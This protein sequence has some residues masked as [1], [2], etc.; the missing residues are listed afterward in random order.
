MIVDGKPTEPGK[1]EVIPIERFL[2]TMPIL[3]RNKVVI[4]E[5]ADRIYHESVGSILKTLEEPQSYAKFVLTSS[6]IGSVRPTIISRCISI[7]CSLPDGLE[8][9]IGEVLERSRRAEML[10]EIE[11]IVDQSVQGEQGGAL[12]LSDRVRAVAD[13]LAEAETIPKRN[14]QAQIIEYIA[15]AFAS[16][17]ENK[18]CA[19]AIEIHRRVLMNGSFGLN[20]DALFTGI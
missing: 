12:R 7:S 2:R 17:G 18:R 11:S 19:K 10:D 6:F 16:R 9:S 20:L 14:A 15:D 5:E 8:N 13:N 3:S 1:P 4:I